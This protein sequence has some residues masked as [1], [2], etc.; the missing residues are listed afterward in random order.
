MGAWSVLCPERE[1]GQKARCLPPRP[2]SL[3]GLSTGR[4]SAAQTE[5][6]IHAIPQRVRVSEAPAH[7]L[8]KGFL[9]SSFPWSLG[10]GKFQ[11]WLP[12]AIGGSLPTWHSVSPHVALGRRLGRIASGRAFWWEE[13]VYTHTHLLFVGQRPPSDPV[14]CYKDLENSKELVYWQL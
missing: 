1:C 10:P 3:L 4:R 12:P 5:K 2:Q 11:T 14:I 8:G 9:S 6:Q 13:P 7:G